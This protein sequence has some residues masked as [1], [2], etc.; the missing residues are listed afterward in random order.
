MHGFA[1]ALPA[2]RIVTLSLP[3]SSTNKGFGVWSLGPLEGL[4]F[5]VDEFGRS[6]KHLPPSSFLFPFF[7]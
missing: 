2:G 5:G 4:G 7:K 1:A 3:P 6:T